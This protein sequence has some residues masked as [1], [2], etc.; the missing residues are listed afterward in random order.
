M[1]IPSPIEKLIPDVD[2]LLG[3]EPEE[4]AWF[5]LK[6]AKEKLQNGMFQP[7]TIIEKFAGSGMIATA[8]FC[9]P[10]NKRHEVDI[11]LAEAWNWLRV[12]SLVI[13]APGMNGNNGWLMFSR[14]ALRI[15]DDRDFQAFKEAAAFPRS[16][17]HPIIADKTWLALARGDLEEAVFFAF[18]TVEVRVRQAARLDAKDIGVALM[19]KAFDAESGPLTDKSQPESERLSLAHLFA[20]AIGSYKNPHSHRTVSIADPREAQEMVLLAT[21][22][23]RIVDSREGASTSNE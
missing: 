4:L 21:H 11:A 16:L 18:K 17:L 23:L 12:N 19:R 7:G 5:L 9:Y 8:E 14:R 3:L 6:G 1:N 15:I 2:V 13:P 22:L 20:G 10:A